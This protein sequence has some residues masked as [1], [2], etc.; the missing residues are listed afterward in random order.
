VIARKNKPS[1]SLPQPDNWQG[2]HHIYRQYND[3]LPSDQTESKKSE[4]KYPMLL[5][6]ESGVTFIIKLQK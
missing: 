1:F 6:F 2:Y 4:R 3:Q 5:L